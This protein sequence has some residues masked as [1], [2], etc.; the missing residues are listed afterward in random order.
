M[1]THRVMRVVRPAFGAE[2]SQFFSTHP[3][4]MS[5]F[6]Q[7]GI[8]CTFTAI[9]IA[10]MG[11]NSTSTLAKGGYSKRY[12]P[13]AAGRRPNA[14]RWT[15]A[16]AMAARRALELASCQPPAQFLRRAAVDHALRSKWRACIRKVPVEEYDRAMARRI[17]FSHLDEMAAEPEAAEASVQRML[18]ALRARTAAMRCVHVAPALPRCEQLCVSLQELQAV[19][20]QQPGDRCRDTSKSFKLLARLSQWRLQ[21]GTIGALVPE[22]A[23]S[24]VKHERR[25]SLTFPRDARFRDALVHKLVLPTLTASDHYFDLRA[26]RWWSPR[27]V[28]AAFGVPP[29]SAISACLS[30]AE[31]PFGPKRLVAALGRSVC[32]PVMARVIHRAVQATLPPPPAGEEATIRYG[33]L[34][35]GIDLSAVALESLVAGSLRSPPPERLQ[36]SRFEYVLAAESDADL[37]GLLGRAWASRGLRKPHIYED[38]RSLLQST[39]PD[40]HLL[41]VTPECCEFSPRK[42]GRMRVAQAKALQDT[43]DALE[44]VRRRQ[45]R[46]VVLENV[47]EP[48]VVPFV[49]DMLGKIEAYRWERVVID[50]AD[51]CGWPMHRRRAYWIGMR[52]SKGVWW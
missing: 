19:G 16:G 11:R 37:R 26:W 3:P 28:A 18:R 38:A 48:G 27:E 34:F 14:P 30:G 40:V 36:V 2:V 49:D 17:V 32:V 33:S 41:V 20:K 46:A 12:K 8:L 13:P 44:Y 21:P 43:S 5:F 50:P 7:R 6:P 45:P 42:R 52:L 9:P 23:R 1:P 31:L 29:S 10:A 15:P 51:H 47:D 22:R 25:G 4:V 24:R 39:V 35:S